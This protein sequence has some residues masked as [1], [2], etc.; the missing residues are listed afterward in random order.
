MISR[1]GASDRDRRREAFASLCGRYWDPVY[2]YVRIAWSKSGE[3]AKDL[4]QAFFLWVLEDDRLSRCEREGGTFRSYLKVVLRRFV[5]HREA[6]LHR[7]K[8][9]G[10]ARIVPLD[11]VS[12]EALVQPA[13]PEAAFD[14]AWLEQ[15]V[16]E[17]VERVRVRLCAQ[18]KER[19]F[20]AYER[21]DLDRAKSYE[22]VA[23]ELGLKPS[24]VRNHL[25]AVR[26]AVRKEM[27]LQLAQTTLD[28]KSFE[29]EWN[30]LF[31]A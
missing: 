1:L 5:G 30:E 22:D 28:E 29:A 17:S 6:A 11:A 26:R 31:G 4:T 19:M 12:T 7:L 2:R 10:G 23:A 21:Y 8:R 15:I 14:R 9:G 3:E 25:F 27:R 16:R 24:D 18:G 13:D 20:R